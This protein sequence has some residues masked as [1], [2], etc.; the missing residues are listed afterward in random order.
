MSLS[1]GAFSIPWTPDELRVRAEVKPGLER[2]NIMP[3]S[4]ALDSKDSQQSPGQIDQPAH[5][6]V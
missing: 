3:C 6:R 4:I 2:H 1:F 5:L